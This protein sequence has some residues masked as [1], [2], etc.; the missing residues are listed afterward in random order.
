MLLLCIGRE[1]GDVI[2]SG[3]GYE[4]VSFLGNRGE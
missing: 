1:P 4:N 3:V 2:I